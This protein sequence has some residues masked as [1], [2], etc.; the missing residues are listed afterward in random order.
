M[1]EAGGPA[2]ELCGQKEGPSS[3]VSVWLAGGWR[4]WGEEWWQGWGELPASIH[5]PSGEALLLALGTW[6]SL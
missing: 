5:I 1:S 4:G 3:P 6:P 2:T